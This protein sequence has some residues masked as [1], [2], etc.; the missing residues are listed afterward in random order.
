MNI[1]EIPIQDH[2]DKPTTL[3]AYRGHVLLIVNVASRCGFT[4]QYA[5]LEKLYQ[6]LKPQKFTI[7]GFPCN[8]F[9]QQEPGSNSEIQTFAT[10][11][12]RVT[13]PIMGKVDVKGPNQAPLYRYLQ[14]QMQRK[15]LW[16]VPWNFTKILIDRKGHVLKQFYPMTSINKIMQ[17]MLLETNKH[18]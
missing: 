17:S 12:Y 3:E 4:P 16:F 6:E 9:G 5:A 8:Q 10:E 2:N 11:C 14:Q 13:F 15:P 1:Y 18:M 7:L